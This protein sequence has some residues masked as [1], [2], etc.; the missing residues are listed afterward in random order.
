MNNIKEDLVNLSKRI[1]TIEK[2][3]DLLLLYFKLIEPPAK[4]KESDVLPLI[5]AKSF[6]IPK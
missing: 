2:K 5:L 6:D 3:I 1:E 4:G